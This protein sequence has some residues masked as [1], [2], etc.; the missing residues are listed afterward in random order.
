[1]MSETKHT[2]GP[3]RL[4]CGKEEIVAEECLHIAFVRAHFP[5]HIERQRANAELIAAAPEMLELLRDLH[6]FCGP[7]AGM[8]RDE[9]KHAVKAKN[10]AGELLKRL[11]G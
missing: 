8:T 5:E 2:P 9:T 6:D 4:V 10:R 7:Q 11:G 3:W 1:M